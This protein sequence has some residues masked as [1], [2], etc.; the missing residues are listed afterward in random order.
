[1]VNG[2]FT[3]SRSMQILQSKLDNSSHNLANA[4]TNG[5]KKSLLATHTRV[6]IEHNDEFKLHQD[7]HQKMS[8]N[9]VNYEQGALISTDDP[10]DLAI[11]GD[12]FFELE[13]PNGKRYSRN[14]A[15]TVNTQGELVNLNGYPVLDD[16]GAKISV[17]GGQFA[18]SADGVV[19]VDG[20]RQGKI[21]L[22]VPE[23]MQDFERIG[24]TF[25]ELKEGIKPP[26][27]QGKGRLSQGMLEGSNVNVVD[28]MVQMI[29][30][31]A[32]YDSNS[33]AMQ[34]LDETL[35]KAVNEVGRVG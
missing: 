25:F 2:L 13:T 22:I 32:Q 19:T 29:T 26:D 7:E 34:S 8:V 10:F 18:V 4:N 11:E 20:D 23:N 16:T 14:G 30:I 9:Y 21:S 15:F 27:E 33:K 17:N 3:S 28:S 31:Q 1:M 12:G 6:D 5:F 24:S 35:T